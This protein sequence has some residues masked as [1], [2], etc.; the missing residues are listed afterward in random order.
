M[1]TTTLQD[2]PGQSGAG[3]LPMFVG[4]SSGI[5]DYSRLFL[6]CVVAR[7]FLME[8]TFK[9]ARYD[10]QLFELDCKILAMADHLIGW[11]CEPR[12]WALR[13]DP[14]FCQAGVVAPPDSLMDEKTA[15][16]AGAH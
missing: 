15:L 1:Q 5:S 7:K 8:E 2:I 6:Q 9:S 10:Q 4:F 14:G 3:M 11:G 13:A 16:F 12:D